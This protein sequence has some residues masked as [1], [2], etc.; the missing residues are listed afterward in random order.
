MHVLSHASARPLRQS[1]VAIG[2]LLTTAA[3]LRGDE[4]TSRQVEGRF[5]SG[6]AEVRAFRFEPA[7]SGRQPAVILLH[8]ADGWAQFDAYRFAADGLTACRCVAVLVRYYDRTGTADG[9]SEAQRTEFVRWLKGE[10]AGAAGRRARWHLSEWSAA[11]VDAVE[12]ARSLPNVDP[13]RVAVVGFSLGGYV[14]LAAAPA[15]DPPVRAVVEMFG[16][17]PEELRKTLG[18][19]P[20]TLIVHGEEDTVVPVTE[21]Y[22][23]AG[24]VAAQKQYVEIDVRKGVGHVFARPGTMLPDVAELVRGR[25]RMAVFLTQRLAPHR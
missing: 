12:Y 17:L 14:A 19:L 4:S 1:F 25:D 24:F 22:K 7:G 6:P 23:A 16:G 9:V 11:V 3:T 15:C 8:G 5:R 13:K 21:A 10:A 20:P 2:M 18:N